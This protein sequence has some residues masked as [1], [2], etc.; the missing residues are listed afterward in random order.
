MSLCELVSPAM[1]SGCPF[2]PARKRP[3]LHLPAAAWGM[4]LE[5]FVSLAPLPGAAGWG[6]PAVVAQLSAALLHCFKG[7]ASSGAL[8]VFCLTSS[9][10][11]AWFEL[12]PKQL[13]GILVS[14]FL[15]G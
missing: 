3:P 14:S 11:Q 12:S 10:V 7:C 5:L 4:L 6:L 9:W 2:G 15:M 13:F 8:Q 1:R